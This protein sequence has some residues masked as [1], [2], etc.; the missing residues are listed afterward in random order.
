MRSPFLPVS[1]ACALLLSANAFA[2]DYPLA[3]KTITFVLPYAAGGPTDKAARDLA[4][5]MKKI[6]PHLIPFRQNKDLQLHD[7]VK[8]FYYVMLNLLMANE[9]K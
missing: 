1:F 4:Q 3:N 9:S 7:S 6:V 8:I 2:Q 5:A